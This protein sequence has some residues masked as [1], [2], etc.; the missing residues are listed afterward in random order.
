MNLGVQFIQQTTGTGYSNQNGSFTAAYTGMRFG[1]DQAQVVSVG[2]QAGFISRKF[3]PSKF[4]TG[5]QWTPGSGFIPG[6]GANETMQ[7]KSVTGF[8]AG[9]GVMYYDMSADKKVNPYFG[10]S[11]A[12][13]TRPEASFLQNGTD[14][15]PV[16]YTAHGGVAIKVSDVFMVNPNLLYQRQGSAEEKMA[17]VYG[18]YAAAEQLDLLGGLYYRFGDAVV[19][20][21][22]LDYKRFLVGLSYD[23]NNSDL[24]RSIVNANTYEVSLSY[25]FR[26]KKIL[27]GRNLS[28]PRL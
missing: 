22:G 20:F 18:Q 24:G 15:V 19:P 7:N 12:H 10:L 9:V 21:I 4:E 8:D 28:C 11:A 26:K 25:I 13:L 5:D 23:V 1:R 27:Q 3:D 6:T 2:I 17:G 16:R 14:R